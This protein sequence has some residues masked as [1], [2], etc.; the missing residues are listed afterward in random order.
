VSSCQQDGQTLVTPADDVTVGYLASTSTTDHG[1]V[2]SNACPW[3]IQVSNV[4][5][6]GLADCY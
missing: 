5:D 3:R 6:I 2:G 4:G 1:G